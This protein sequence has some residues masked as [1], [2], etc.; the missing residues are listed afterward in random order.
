[1]RVFSDTWTICADADSP[2]V[3]RRARLHV[4]AGHRLAYNVP[5]GSRLSTIPQAVR[6]QRTSVHLSV[7][8]EHLEVPGLMFYVKIEQLASGRVFVLFGD[9]QSARP[10][11]FNQY[12]NS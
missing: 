2:R 12:I 10:C 7:W 8:R 5:R 9:N 11:K 3:D 6:L 1:M 4:G